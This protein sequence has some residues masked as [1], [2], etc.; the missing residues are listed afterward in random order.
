MDDADTMPL[1]ASKKK[2]CGKW[3][4]LPSEIEFK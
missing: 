1:V 3:N 4:D 2:V